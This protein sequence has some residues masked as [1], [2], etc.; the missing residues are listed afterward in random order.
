MNIIIG[1]LESKFGNKKIEETSEG[2][3]KEKCD[4][5]TM[6][7]TKLIKLFLI[8]NIIVIVLA[9]ISNGCI[10]Y[11]KKILSTQESFYGIMNIDNVK[12][13]FIVSS[14]LFLLLIVLLT[15][16]YP[17]YTYFKECETLELDNNK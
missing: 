17:F 13:C 12:L 7:K 3:P 15:F 2:I 6:N 14:V 8:I 10:L 9:F 5:E 16:L 11:I 1:V 4:K